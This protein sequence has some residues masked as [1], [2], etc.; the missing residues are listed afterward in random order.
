MCAACVVQPHTL[1]TDRS[2]S[3]E[4]LK[5]SNAPP[6]RRGHPGKPPNT[7]LALTPRGR[8]QGKLTWRG[9]R[10]SV[11]HMERGES[12]HGKVLL[13][14]RRKQLVGAFQAVCKRPQKATYSPPRIGCGF[15]LLETE[16]NPG[17]ESSRMWGLSPGL[18]SSP[19]CRHIHVT[20][21]EWALRRPEPL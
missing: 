5:C 15:H 11:S 1:E 13:H 18:Q 16:E 4:I 20:P 9:E 7:T 17:P 19:W 12:V 6:A 2:S 14:V 3:V 10:C 21:R 8:R